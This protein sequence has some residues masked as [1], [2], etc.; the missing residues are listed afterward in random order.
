M[1][2]SRSVDEWVVAKAVEDGNTTQAPVPDEVIGQFD[3]QLTA[4]IAYVTVVCRLPRRVAHRLL[5]GAL[6]IPISLGSTHAAWEEAS[7]AV[8][9]PCPALAQALTHQPVVNGDET[10]H[11]TNGAKRSLWVLVAPRFVVYRIAATRG[12]GVLRDLLGPVFPGI[13]CSGRWASYTSLDSH[14]S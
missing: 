3:P 9:A 10:G 8:A 14:V 7:D 6:Q 2:D 13:L 1:I 11:R 5:E 12:V 4:L